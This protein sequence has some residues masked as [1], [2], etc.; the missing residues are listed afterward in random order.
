MSQTAADLIERVQPFHLGARFGE[1]LT[2]AIQELNNTDKHRLIPVTLVS[3]FA[4]S[5]HMTLDDG[6]RIELLPWEPEVRE[7]LADG[8]EIVR[9]RVPDN[10]T[11]A[12]FNV[13]VGVDIAFEQVGALRNHPV[14]DLLVK[15][16]DY[17]SR[18]VNT[19]EPEFAAFRPIAPAD[20]AR[21]G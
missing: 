7:P 6:T 1:A 4:A 20:P 18:L 17:V 14:N 12:T 16:T 10:A 9:V 19:F 21:G 11:G 8:A 2:W 13:P 15:S 5:V 3:A